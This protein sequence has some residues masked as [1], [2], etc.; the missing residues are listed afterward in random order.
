MTEAA[1]VDPAAEVTR[2]RAGARSLRRRD[3][4]SR[5][6]YIAELRRVVL[7]RREEI[8]DRIQADTGKS[9]SDALVS[10][11]FGT[12]DVLAWTERHALRH[13]RPQKVHTPIT[14]LGKRSETWFEP[15]GTV[16]IIAPWNYPFFQA[17]AP[18]ALAIACGNTVV[19]KPS[20]W[21]PLTGLIEDLHAEAQFAPNW[22]RVVYGDG[23][24]GAALIDAGPDRVMFTGSTKTG[25]A[26]LERA[27]AR[28]IPGERTLGGQDATNVRHDR[29]RAASSSPSARSHASRNC[30]RISVASGMSFSPGAR[31]RHDS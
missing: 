13:L 6:G 11:I 3:L 4:R 14:L 28:L 31:S 16:L 15:L 5:L 22:V 24:V 7:R 25:R 23:A 18:I 30:R 8:I 17:L 12:L 9:R 20:E 2:A 19:F 29:R 21:T 10:E 27:D 1:P 26:V